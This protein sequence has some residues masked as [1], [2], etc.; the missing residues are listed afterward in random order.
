MHSQY[1]SRLPSILTGRWQNIGPILKILFRPFI[2]FSLPFFASN[3]IV[4][5]TTD[6]GLFG[7]KL[8]FFFYFFFFFCNK[9]WRI[10]V[11]YRRS[12]YIFLLL[13]QVLVLSSLFMAFTDGH[14]SVDVFPLVFLDFL[15]VK[16]PKVRWSSRQ[17]DGPQ[18]ANCCCSW[19][20]PRIEALE[21]EKGLNIDRNT[22]KV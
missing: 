4:L 10:Y 20:G 8:P 9:H 1:Q 21:S 15:E 13:W 19:N 12:V 16:V 17:Y 6:E 3:M 5:L 14:V 2:G 18:E 11:V 22:S 7:A